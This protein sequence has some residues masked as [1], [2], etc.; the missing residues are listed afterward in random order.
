MK[1][2]RRKTW[3]GLATFVHERL[4]CHC[5]ISLQI[6]QRLTGCA[7][8]SQDTRSSTSTNLHARDLHQ[9]PSW[10]SHTPV[11]TLTT[12]IASMPTGV[13]TSPD[14]ESLESWATSN[15]F[16][17]LYNPKETATLFSRRWNVGTNPDLAFASFGQD[18][19]LLD[20][21]VLWKFPRSQHQLSLITTPRLK[22]PAHSNPVKRWSFHKVD[23]K[24]FCLLT[25]ESVE[26]LLPPDTPNIERATRSFA[27]AHYPRLNNAG[28]LTWT[29]EDLCAMLGQ[30]VRARPSIASSSEPQWGLTLIEPLRPYCV[31]Y[32]RRNRS[33]G[34][35]PL[36]TST[37]RTLAAR[38]GEP[39]TNLLAGMDAS[40][41]RAPSRQTPSP[42]NS[43]KTEHT[44]PRTASPPGSLKRSCPTYGRS[45]HMR[46]TVSLNPLGRTSLLLPSYTWNQESIRDWI[47]SSGSLYSMP[48]RHSNLGFATSSVPACA[49]SKFQRS[50]EEH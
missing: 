42:H 7:L 26:R 20:R 4:E 30:R 18:T 8:A 5:S 45:Q 11:C 15:N 21:R 48:G 50:G 22:V 38:R 2:S 19:R 12:S 41:A 46:V 37:S 49:N 43:W 29:S 1:I 39:S 36:I 17:L 27:R 23:W 6:N 40:L 14:G 3:H 24:R 47:P 9:R 13:T 28:Y 34:R 33:D 44:G 25:G 32:N 35:Q 16:G 10:R 31:R